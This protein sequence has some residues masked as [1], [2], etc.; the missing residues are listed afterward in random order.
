M[1]EACE[2]VKQWHENG[3]PTFSVTVNLSPRQLQDEIPIKL[4]NYRIEVQSLK[5]YYNG[6][7]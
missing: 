2:Q 3:F 1:K 7:G 4:L 5:I 6:K